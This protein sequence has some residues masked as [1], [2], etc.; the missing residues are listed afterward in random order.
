VFDKE[1]AKE[2]YDAAGGYPGP[3]ELWVNGDGGH[4]AWAEAV[5]NQIKNNLDLECVVQTTPDFKTLRDRIGARELKGIMR[6]GWQM[7]Y[8]SIENFMTPLYA[9]GASA[10][11]GDYSNPEFDR[12]MRDAAAA[13]T[14]E[15][16]NL[17]YQ[18]AQDLL[19]KDFPVMPMWTQESQFGYSTKVK[20]IK[21]TPFST[22]DFSTVELAS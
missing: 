14:N 21:M 10:N 12:L 8:P 15:Q 19:N 16:A 7:D 3:L 18:Q 13:S 17:L 20:S 9:T 1:K 11:D 22:F 4:E 5:C 6:A 2:L